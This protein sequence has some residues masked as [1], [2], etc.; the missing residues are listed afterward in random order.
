VLSRPPSKTLFHIRVYIAT[1]KTHGSG[2]FTGENVPKGTNVITWGGEVFS[3]DQVE[4]GYCE[5]HTAIQISQNKWLGSSKGELRDASDYMNHSCLANVGLSGRFELIALSDIRMNT[6]LTGDYSTWLNNELY[7]I[8]GECR[9]GQV[10]CRKVIRG[11][12]WRN[13]EFAQK[14]Y[15]HL[16]TYIKLLVDKFGIFK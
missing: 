12:E 8:S 11:D 16:S 10:S 15:D 5:P 6:E 9:C 3:S 2:L 1:S 7:Q 4:R 14:K 13:R